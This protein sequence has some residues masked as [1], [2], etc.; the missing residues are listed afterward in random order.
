MRVYVSKGVRTACTMNDTEVHHT[1]ETKH[2]PCHVCG[3]FAPEK[4]LDH[5][6]RDPV[7][8][9]HCDAEMCEA[10]PRPL[11][12]VCRHSLLACLRCATKMDF[13]CLVCSASAEPMV[14]LLSRV[15]PAVSTDVLRLVAEYPLRR[16]K[17]GRCDPKQPFAP[18]WRCCVCLEPSCENCPTESCLYCINDRI[19]CTACYRA[20]VV[21]C[22]TCQQTLGPCHQSCKLVP[23][24]C[25]N[26]P[27]APMC[28]INC[29][30]RG[31]PSC[32]WCNVVLCPKCTKLLTRTCAG[33]HESMLYCHLHWNECRCSEPGKVLCMDC[34]PFLCTVC[35]VTHCYLCPGACEVG[36]HSTLSEAKSKVYHERMRKRKRE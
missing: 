7:P 13:L 16:C 2:E 29:V 20:L 22:P 31:A 18:A 6:V 34:R 32:T 21:H 15:L 1:E 4:G 36:V 9:D 11:C 3:V 25:C 14:G 27:D 10:C 30:D 28:C 33:C 5:A 24:R 35:H 17:Q 8:C 12:K 26:D 19:M 23:P